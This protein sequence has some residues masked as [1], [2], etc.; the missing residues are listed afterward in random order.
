MKRLRAIRG[1]RRCQ[2]RGPDI[3]GAGEYEERLKEES[4]GMGGD[5]IIPR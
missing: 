3:R 2:R 1:D 4:G 5:A